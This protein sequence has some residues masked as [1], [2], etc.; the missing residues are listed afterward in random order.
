[1]FPVTERHVLERRV[2]K[3]ML[4]TLTLV[5]ANAREAEGV[6][7]IRIGIVALV[8]VYRVRGSHDECVLWD[9][10]TVWQR[11]ILEHLARHRGWG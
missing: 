11:D 4:C 9:K 6:K 10:C 1:M 2:N 3:L 7:C 5:L 8:M